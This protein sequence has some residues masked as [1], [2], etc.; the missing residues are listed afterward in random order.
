MPIEYISLLISKIAEISG[1]TA[2]VLYL[3]MHAF[4][5]A[6]GIYPAF[7]VLHEDFFPK[8]IFK[9]RDYT[10]TKNSKLRFL[11][12]LFLISIL[13]LVPSILFEFFLHIREAPIPIIITVALTAIFFLPILGIIFIS[14]VLCSATR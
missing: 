3:F 13:F 2:V 10:K 4:L 12:Y 8:S 5:L 7:R 14:V 6:N 11:Y 1:I 9:F